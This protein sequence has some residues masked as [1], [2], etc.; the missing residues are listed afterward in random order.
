MSST[1]TTPT[2]RPPEAIG[3]ETDATD[4]KKKPKPKPKPKQKQ[5][6]VSMLGSDTQLVPFE[7]GE[8]I[9]GLKRKLTRLSGVLENPQQ[10]IRPEGETAEPLP[11]DATVE[12]CGLTDGSNVTCVMMPSK[13][14]AFRSVRIRF[15]GEFDTNGMLHYLGTRGNTVPYT[16][17]H[18]SGQVTASMSACG[19]G[20]SEHRFVQ[21]A[22]SADDGDHNFT[23]RARHSWMQVDLG[24][25]RKLVPTHYC[26]RHGGNYP[27][28]A[29]KNWRLQASND[30]GATW[31]TLRTHTRD[32]S[33]TGAIFAVAAWSVEDVG[34]AY[35]WFRIIQT[36]T[37]AA[38]KPVAIYCSGIELYGEF[39]GDATPQAPA[40]DSSCA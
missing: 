19:R 14:L 32:Q 30:A 37:A 7:T 6:C 13:T 34:E 17:P 39:Y 24:E 38:V 11:N 12:M 26:L 1:Q 36:P 27:K 40:P 22:Q 5:I 20:C 33:L 28:V 15:N 9:R 29:L 4:P 10:W 25:H 35:R 3:D 8:T 31:A 16:N 2:K 21:H 18:T 23:T